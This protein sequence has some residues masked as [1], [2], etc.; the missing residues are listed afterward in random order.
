MIGIVD[1]PKVG[2]KLGCKGG[3]SLGVYYWDVEGTTEGTMFVFIEGSLEYIS[4]GIFE[5][6]SE[7]VKEQSLLWF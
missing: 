6:Y 4:L 1:Y 7:V 2:R 5:L 3:T